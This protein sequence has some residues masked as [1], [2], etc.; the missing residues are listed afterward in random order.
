V[1]F[2]EKAYV[3]VI[4]LFLLVVGLACLV[5]PKR[6]QTSARKW[7]AVGLAARVKIFRHHIASPG[8]IWS[9]RLAGVLA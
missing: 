4:S 5:S 9:T 1:S 2:S 8:Y 7:T 3:F 6:I